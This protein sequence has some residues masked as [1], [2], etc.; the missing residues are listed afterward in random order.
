M[1]QL[2]RDRRRR[3]ESVHGS[4][5]RSIWPIVR[6]KLDASRRALKSFPNDIYFIFILKFF[7]SYSYFALSQILVIYMH[8][9]FGVSDLEAGA[10]YGMWGASI[11]LGGLLMSWINDNLGVRKSL[12]V[13]FTISAISSIITACTTSKTLLYITI[14]GIYP[15]GT[16][17]GIPMLTVAIK[18]YTIKKNRT[19]AFG[20][21]YSV[22]NIAALFSGPM[23][24]MFNIGFKNG[25]TVNGH[26]WSG[27]R[28]V[29]FTCTIANILSFLVTHRFIRNIK[30][31]DDVAA[32]DKKDDEHQHQHQ[33]DKVNEYEHGDEGEDDDD[34]KS[35]DISGYSGDDNRSSFGFEEQDNQEE[36]NGRHEESDYDMAGEVKGGG[37]QQEIEGVGDDDHDDEVVVHLNETPP[38]S[39][40][41]VHG[42]NE[43][44]STVTV[45]TPKSQTPWKTMQ[46][47]CQS[48]TF[49]R[50][51][52][53]T[54][55]LVNLHAIFRHLDATEPTYLIRMFG[56][57]VPKGTIYSIN[58][59]MIIF[60][61]PLVGSLTADYDDF[62]MIMYGGYLS[63]LSPFFVAASTSIWA[64]VC[65]NITLSLGEAVWSPRLY[66]YVMTIAPEV[67]R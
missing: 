17:M 21:Y 60:L 44:K 54:L 38:S 31:V 42:S 63:A 58:P 57:S 11:T 59:F 49:W 41:S 29:I 37:A 4:K 16:A 1:R 34:D 12:L 66:D 50:F 22:M 6:E 27:N 15:I 2:R 24:D 43:Y 51:S 13:G 47:L 61:T 3:Y 10:A 20:L 55:L 32:I 40:F 28:C 7:E 45:H 33:Q 19:F 8:T 9:E 46:E 52:V 26:T 23:V 48:P 65:M 30:L 53:L 64:I 56:D 18:R 25:I 35:I 62:N 39:S 5:K 14:F 36:N 67:G